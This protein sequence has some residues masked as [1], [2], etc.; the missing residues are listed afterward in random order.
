MECHDWSAWY[1][2][3]PG[4]DDPCLHVSGTCELRSSSIQIELR[5]GEVFVP[6]PG[7]LAL[8]LVATIP[9]IGD[10]RIVDREVTW[11]DNVG[12]D[13]ELVWIRGETSTEIKVKIV[14]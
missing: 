4:V 10:D 1:N 3:L 8:D 11:S 13:I 5:P 9:S 14:R 6:E 7:L 12:P 2:R